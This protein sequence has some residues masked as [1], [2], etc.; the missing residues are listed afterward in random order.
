M[1]YAHRIA[2]SGNAA[3]NIR[4][5]LFLMNSTMRPDTKNWFVDRLR[6]IESRNAS[7]DYENAGS[8]VMHGFDLGATNWVLG[9]DDS[10]IR[11][12]FGL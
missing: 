6:F 8:V 5:Y 2:S 3:D 9:C 4:G 11:V 12:S 1:S 7:R 10:M